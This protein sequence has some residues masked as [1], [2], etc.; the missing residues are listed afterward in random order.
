MRYLKKKKK[1][2]DFFYSFKW[3]FDGIKECFKRELNF[4]F[5]TLATVC[6]L[7]FSY[8]F[9]IPKRDFILLLFCIMTV[10][11]AELINTIAEEICDLI[12]SNYNK[13]IKYIK[14][15][16][17]GTVLISAMFSV[18]IGLIIFVPYFIEFFKL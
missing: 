7:L 13:R 16:S 12:D 10:L 11:M 8:I 5:H 4:R 15:L 6:V 17:A 14:D 2:S 18:I 1:F 3:A 9:K